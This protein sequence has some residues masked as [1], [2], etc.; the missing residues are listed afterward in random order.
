MSKPLRLAKARAEKQVRVDGHHSTNSG[1][2]IR[3]AFADNVRLLL[4]AGDGGSGAATFRRDKSTSKGGP[5]GGNG[6][7]GGHVIIKATNS[8]RDLFLPKHI[9]RARHGGKGRGKQMDGKRAPDELVLV[10]PGTVLKVWDVHAASSL[11]GP[12]GSLHV[13]G[14]TALQR[15]TV[16][17]HSP[18]VIHRMNSETP[19]A[20]IDLDTDGQEI[21]MVRGGKGGLGNMSYKSGRTVAPKFSQKGRCVYI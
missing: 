21:I 9:V 7:E 14:S 20:T 10:P 4:E 13:T 6:G 11:V 15:R 18:K 2:I 5:D 12:A 3:K 17:L 16:S 8:V 1:Q 19:L